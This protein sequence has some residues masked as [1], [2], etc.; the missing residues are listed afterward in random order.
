[1]VATADRNYQ[2]RLV[3]VTGT[4]ML[5]RVALVFLLAMVAGISW[6]NVLAGHDGVEYLTMAEHLAKGTPTSIPLEARRHDLGW[7]LLLAFAARFLSLPLAAL[8]LQLAL[9]AAIVIQTSL[10]AVA[11][12]G[13]SPQ[14]SLR[15]AAAAVLAYPAALYYSA[16]ALSEPFFVTL[17]LA[18]LLLAHHGRYVWAGFVAGMAATVRSPAILLLPPLTWL[19]WTTTACLPPRRRIVACVGHLACALLP[20]MA[21]LLASY[22]L[23]GTH[24]TSLHSPRFSWPLAGFRELFARG[25]FRGLY[26]ATCL[27]V[28]GLAVIKFS[29]QS[30]KQPMPT[31]RA[32]TFFSALFLAFHLCLE[33]LVYYGHRI[34]LVDYFDRYLLPLWPFVVLAT[35]RWWRWWFVSVML[36]VSIFMSVYWGKNYFAAVKTHGAPMLEHLRKTNVSQSP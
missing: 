1:M 19:C 6:K 21:I 13:V 5:V 24:A 23:W 11:L 9:T 28:T 33:S 12:L 26:V 30:L 36:A 34:Y 22:L 27:A 16:F 20:V 8:V 18:S 7:P 17:I 14:D 32:I 25:F 15:L 10:L 35:P 31:L 2:L 29:G 3:G 4:A